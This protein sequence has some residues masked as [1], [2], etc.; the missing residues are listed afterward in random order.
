MRFVCLMLLIIGLAVNG[1]AQQVES[2]EFHLYT[3]S[4]KKGVYNYINVDGKLSDG[5]WRPL[6]SKQLQF[7]SNTGSWD[8]N[9]LIIDSSYNKD[10][11]VVIASLKGNAAM[12]KK[13][14]IYMKKDLSNPLLKTEDQLMK[15]MN[16]SSS[17]KSRRK[18]NGN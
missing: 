10:S 12:Q 3:D 15:E 16:D 6:G 17:G 13:I 2:I 5:S 7:S 8:G 11:V 4:L 14:T 18:R 1:K 9:S